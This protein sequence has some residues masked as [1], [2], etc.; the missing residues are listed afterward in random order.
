MTRLFMLASALLL[1]ACTQNRGSGGTEMDLA[2]LTAKYLELQRQVDDMHSKLHEVD[3][4]L[5]DTAYFRPSSQG[6]QVVWVDKG[7]L[8]VQVRDLKPMDGGYRVTF[9]IGNPMYASFRDVRAQVSWGLPDLRGPAS[10][11]SAPEGRTLEQAV[12]KELKPGSLTTVS[13]DVSPASGDEIASFSIRLKAS[14]AA[15][16]RR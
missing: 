1:T 5:G 8:Y 15:L 16:V 9:D 6:F 7:F 2:T 4:R 14:S 13:F 10:D 12:Q 11:E 3:R